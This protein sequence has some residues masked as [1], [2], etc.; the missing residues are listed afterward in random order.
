MLKRKLAFLLLLTLTV[1]TLAGCQNK[2]EPSG[3]QPEKPPTTLEQEEPIIPEDPPVVEAHTLTPE[4]LEAEKYRDSRI[5]LSELNKNRCAFQLESETF[6]LPFSYTR[7]SEQW[8]FIPSYYDLDDSFMLQPGQCTSDSIVLFNKETDSTLTVGFYNPYEM[9]CS[10]ADAMIWSISISIADTDD[11]P[12]LTL[13]GKLGWN[14]SIVD[15]TLAYSPPSSPF[16]H[17]FDTKLF[18]F[19]YVSDNY[20]TQYSLTIH[21]ED[22]IIGFSMKRYV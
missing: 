15:V 14:S 19:S 12:Q 20:D 6:S 5:D 10:I 4:L 17:D 22:G 13:P 1:C 7:I 3:K 21:E 8:E 18:T 9:E 11:K 16:D 2:D